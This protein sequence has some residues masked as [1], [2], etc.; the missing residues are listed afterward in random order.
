MATYTE[1]TK[2][3]A[4]Y[5]EDTKHTAVYSEDANSDA[6]SVAKY[7]VARFGQAKYGNVIVE[8]SYTEDTMN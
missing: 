8:R 6:R 2:H 1:D 5:S 3:T 4:V 7:G